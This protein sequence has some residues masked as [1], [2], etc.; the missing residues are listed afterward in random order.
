VQLARPGPSIVANAGEQSRPRRFQLLLAGGLLLPAIVL[1]FGL[2]VYPLGYE[3]VL[4]LTDQRVDAPGSFVG[5][6]NYLDLLA[7]RRF[8]GAVATTGVYV[9]VATALKVLLGLAMALALAR[10]FP[11]RPLIFLLLLVPW[12]YPAVLSATALQWMLNPVLYSDVILRLDRINHVMSIGV[13][14][15]WPLARIILIDVWRGTAFFGVF[16]LVG[17][18]AIPAALLEVAA[19]EGAGP[20]SVFRQVTLPLL[21]P[22][23]LLAVMLSFGATL[24]DFT[25]LYLLTGG[26]ESVHVVG[27]LA[28]EIALTRGDLGLGAATS[29]AL[30]PLV[31]L[32]MLATVRL[33]D[34]EAG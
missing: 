19:L 32:I 13:E 22:A 10:P 34:R 24:A 31:G 26:R 4:S 30:V 18:N 11:G 21:R 9:V 23:L 27:T 20:W 3:A 14:E 7:D 17:R 2:I 16:L 28:Y 8:W 15:A 6:A 25:N 33:L 12:F 1:V 5:L 29:L